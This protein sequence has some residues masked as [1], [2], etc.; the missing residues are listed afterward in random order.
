MD[1]D[2]DSESGYGFTDMDPN[3][4]YIHYH[5]SVDSIQGE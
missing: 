4:D 5:I 2:T 3:T 1:P